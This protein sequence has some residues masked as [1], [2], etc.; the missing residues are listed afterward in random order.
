VENQPVSLLI[1]SVRGLLLNQT[2][3][4][5][6]GRTLV[7]NVALLAV[8]IPLSLWLYDRRTAR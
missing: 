8:L 6:I 5:V 1:D 4:V 2:D 7:W 3:P